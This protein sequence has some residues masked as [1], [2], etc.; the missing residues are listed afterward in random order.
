[1]SVASYLT[2]I[3]PIPVG[4]TIFFAGQSVPRNFVLAGGGTLLIADY[5][6]LFAVMG[7]G[8]G[9][10][11]IT[12][13]GVPDL[14]TYFIQ[15]ASVNSGAV[16]PASPVAGATS[17][18]VTLINANIPTHQAT[19]VT[20]SGGATLN[21]GGGATYHNVS[22]GSGGSATMVDAN[23]SVFGGNNSDL[24][25][26]GVNG[27]TSGAFTCKYANTA[28]AF[29]PTVSAT[30]T[31]GY[32]GFLPIIRYTNQ[33]VHYANIPNATPIPQLNNN[34]LSNIPTLSGY[35]YSQ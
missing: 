8:W 34:P 4:T 13:F 2:S 11:G 3:T 26:T 1:M 29:T 22:I 10:D 25:T 12:T 9:G 6:E 35:I 32:L 20:G 19:T 21:N 7:T 30:A 24:F 27:G 15:G 23:S 31:S 33:L 14:I 16:V 5:P 18:S 28:T 17:T